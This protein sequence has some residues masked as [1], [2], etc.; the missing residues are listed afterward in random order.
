[1][2]SPV[3]TGMQWASE[4]QAKFGAAPGAQTA[5]AEREKLIALCNELLA[6]RER[7]RAELARNEAQRK[8]LQKALLA[9]VDPNPAVIEFDEE[10]AL[11]NVGRKPTMDDLI[12]ELEGQ[13]EEG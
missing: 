3:E 11:A 7:L 10:A 13:A 6:E 1:M 4:F 8:Q 5:E 2:S 9:Y 12:A